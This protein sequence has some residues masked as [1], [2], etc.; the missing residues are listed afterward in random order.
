MHGRRSPRADIVIWET[1]QAK[2]SN[3]TPV[4]VIECKA[5]KHR[6]Q[7]QGLLPGRELQP[8]RRLR[9]LHRPQRSLHRR[10][11]ADSRPAR[12]VHTDK[13]DRDG[14]GLG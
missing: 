9:V 2:A 10:F 4:L 3:K 11:Q 8:R 14:D 7:H 12:R 13:R 5:E 1:H 6:R